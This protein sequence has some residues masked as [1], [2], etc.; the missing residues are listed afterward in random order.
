MSATV[1]IYFDKRNTKK[2][3]KDRYVK[4]CI[5]YHRIQRY[6]ATG[7]IVCEE[8]A[9]FLKHYKGGLTGHVKDPYLRQIWQ[10]VYGDYFIDPETK[11]ECP[12]FLRLG[13]AVLARFSDNFSFEKVKFGLKNYEIIE[14][15]TRTIVGEY[16]NDLIKALEIASNFFFQKEQFGT[17][18]L[19]DNT[20]TSLGRFLGE[21]GNSET[22]SLLPFEK[23]T[24]E[25][26]KDYERWMLRFGKST[27]K[28]DTAPTAASITTI[29]IYMRNIRAAFNTAVDDWK[30][31]S[32]DLYPFGKRKYKIPTSKN[33]KK[34]LPM[35]IIEKIIYFKCGNERE[36]M[37]RDLWVFSYMGNGANF[38]DIVRIQWKDVNLTGNKISF[39]RKKTIRTIKE[40]IEP[41]VV[42][43]LPEMWSIIKKWGSKDRS[44][45][46]FI[47][48]IL[49]NGMLELQK[50]KA[51]DYFIAQT[52]NSLKSIS[53]SLELTVKVRTYE[54][55]H[56][57]ATIMLQSEAPVKFISKKLGHK[58]IATTE[59]YLG[60]F[61]DDKVQEYLQHLVPKN[62]QQI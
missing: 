18:G 24:V 57:F 39:L 40:D 4:W 22:Q 26:L 52:N 8:D 45:Q 60:E 61:E 56:S 10:M 13:R 58:S 28:K 33:I 30:I 44:P 55:R 5:T 19:Y 12:G 27:R 54:A 48:P 21:N 14:N 15:R 43:I 59:K 34:A 20:R 41:V 9:T 53:K 3:S 6:Y 2:G 23:I 47:F 32:K 42:D 25:F 37:H 50:E 62:S 31:V 51:S 49:N 17:A 36:E 29:A 35:S 16:P 7:M 38:A 46:N 11:K 1:T